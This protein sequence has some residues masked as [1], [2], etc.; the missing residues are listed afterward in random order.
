MAT[1][2]TDDKP[3]PDGWSRF[4]HAVDAALHTAPMHK[5]SKA[6]PKTTPRPANIAPKP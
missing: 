6:K 3:D 2:K 1:T 4:E 5:E